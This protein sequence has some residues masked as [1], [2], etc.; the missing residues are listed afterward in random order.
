MTNLF[1]IP[2]LITDLFAAQFGTAGSLVIIGIF[3]GA[4][5]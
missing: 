1:Q 2:N 4:E 5:Y 3:R